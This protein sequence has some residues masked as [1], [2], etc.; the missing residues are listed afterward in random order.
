MA[1]SVK[2]RY[3]TKIDTTDT[4][5]PQGKARNITT[6][7]DG[8]GTP[9]EKDLVNDIM[10][11]QQAIYKEAGITP[12]GTPDTADVSQQLEGLKSITKRVGS[13]V[14]TTSTY[15]LLDSD[16]GKIIEL[17]NVGAITLNIPT[18]LP[19]GF[20]CKILQ[21][22]VGVVTVTP[23]GTTLNSA[24]SLLDTNGLWSLVS[25]EKMYSSETY[26]VSGDTA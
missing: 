3:P 18:S 25:V 2:D 10:G 19:D 6:P 4:A 11:L 26:L 17:S 21:A 1:I 22:G 7:L 24:G 15:T 12:S 14:I 13:I 23:V 8:T 5:Y 9:W 20:S 16:L